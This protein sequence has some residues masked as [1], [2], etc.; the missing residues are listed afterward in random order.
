MLE[1]GKHGARVMPGVS[2]GMDQ[3]AMPEVAMA[4]TSECAA[5]RSWFDGGARPRVGSGCKA[6]GSEAEQGFV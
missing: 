6:R 4:G 1:G 3:G 2:V 5:E